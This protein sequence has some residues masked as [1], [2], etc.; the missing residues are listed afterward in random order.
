METTRLVRTSSLV[1]ASVALLCVL[2]GLA[3]GHPV[4]GGLVGLGMLIG[5][6]NAHLAQ[7]L[8]RTGLPMA[9]TSLVRITALTAVVLVAGL[10]VGLGRVWLVVIGVAA[11]QL[12]TAVSAVLEL[13]RR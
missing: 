12:V 10:A 3:S 5:A 7:R 8:L 4:P 9:S 1:C 11:A 13:T 6:A 2:G